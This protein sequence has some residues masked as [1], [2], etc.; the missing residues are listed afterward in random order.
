MSGGARIAGLSAKA[1]ISLTVV[2]A[3]VLAAKP[4]HYTSSKQ[5]SIASRPAGN[6]VTLGLGQGGERESREKEALQRIPSS[7]PPFL[8][9]SAVAALSGSLVEPRRRIPPPR[10]ATHQAL[11]R[12]RRRA[13]QANDTEPLLS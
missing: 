4:G 11:A 7:K 3:L 8:Q 6:R 1:A 10:W 2:L 5:V 13:P 12:L 9:G